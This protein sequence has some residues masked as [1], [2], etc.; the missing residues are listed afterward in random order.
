HVAGAA[1]A[2]LGQ[3]AH[4]ARHG[5]PQT[6]VVRSADVIILIV[7]V[8]PAPAQRTTATTVQTIIGERPFG[9]DAERLRELLDHTFGVQSFL[10][11]NRCE[12][13]LCDTAPAKTHQ[14]VRL[15]AGWGSF[16]GGVIV[17]IVV[18]RIVLVV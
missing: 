1:R 18:A 4:P 16:P 11:E 15:A 13:V 5:P 7:I 12:L 17:P 8:R 2:R 9:I 10:A 3:R 14:H 6:W